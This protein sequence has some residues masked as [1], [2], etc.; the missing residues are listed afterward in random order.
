M[1]IAQ[2]PRPIYKAFP[3]APAISVGDKRYRT[4]GEL[5]RSTAALAG[6]LRNQ[7][8]LRPGERVALTMSN[9]GPYLEVLFA[10]W[11]AGLVAVPAN[12]KLHAREFE[13]IMEHSG[14]RACF[15]THDL[16]DKLMPLKGKAG[17]L[18][19]VICVED[20]E[21]GRLLAAEPIELW[22]PEPSDPAWL[23]YTSGTTGRPKG[24]TLTHH[25]LI[26][27]SLRY[28]ADVDQVDTSDTMI[29][30]APLSHGS[31]L[32]ALPHMA[33]GSHQVTPSSRGFD[34]AEICDLMGT[35]D[36]ITMFAAPTM[37]TRLVNHP[38]IASA[39]IDAIRT[40]FYGGAPMYVE[41]L[42]RAL[43]VL[44][45][46][47]IDIYGQG[48]SPCTITY[49]PKWL[50][51]DDGHPRFEQRLASVGI[52][53]TGIEVR[54]VDG[55]DCELPPGEVGEVITY[56]DMIMAGY[57]E[58]P[59]ASAET[60]RGGWLHT[61]DV[62]AMD[63]DGFLT[64]KDRSKDMI[65]SGGTNIYP[66]EVEEVL[67]LHPGVLECSVIGRRHPDWGEEVVAFVAVR[68][69]EQVDEDG[70]ER[71][72]LDNIARFKRPK[73]YYFVDQLPKSS[74][75]KILKTELRRRLEAKGEGS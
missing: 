69:G 66:R 28:Y 36:R 25:V 5:G 42:K 46:R 35:Y 34:P 10:I 64:L 73:A 48:E 68:P 67:L 43:K 23:F 47:L 52:A 70:L 49:M 58:N 39:R 74:Y 20:D 37:L 41:D 65:I 26:A 4:Y 53:R 6:A 27:M 59:E 11:H 51:V 14:A 9:C 19:H 56:S 31:G 22:R 29:H 12:A 3:E 24:A 72:C 40:I 15:V 62:G 55:S 30:A 21:Y 17:K 16:A 44:G 38:G 2:L 57:W 71:L 1:N 13:Y 60:L 45:P 50:H 75:G 7:L 8:G 18:E 63:E 61:G 54:V 33:R 32:Y